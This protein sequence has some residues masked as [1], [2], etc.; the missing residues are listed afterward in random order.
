M[1]RRGGGER[2]RNN[3]TRCDDT[4]V[5]SLDTTSVANMERSVRRTCGLCAAND[6][7]M[8]CRGRFFGRFRRRV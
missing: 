8:R 4:S 5:P 2:H 7:P 1:E 3:T 6:M